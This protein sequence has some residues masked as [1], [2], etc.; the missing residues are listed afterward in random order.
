MKY[1]VGIGYDIHRLVAGRKLFIAGLAIPHTKGLLGYSDADVLLHAICDALLGACG[2]ADIG[3]HFPDTDPKYKNISSIKLLKKILESIIKKKNKI[4]NVDT[5]VI[6]EEPNLS[7]YKE[8]MRQSLAKILNIK[9]DCVN[10]KAKTNEG[11]GCI[12]RKNAIAAYA[13]VLLE[14]R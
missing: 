1:K 14:G 6:A 10:I 2:C 3:E 12:G 8:L 11:L 9:N 7:A 5:V 13:V 4:C